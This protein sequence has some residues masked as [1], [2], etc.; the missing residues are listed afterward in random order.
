MSH[1]KF[2]SK[3]LQSSSKSDDSQPSRRKRS[4]A[5]LIST[6]TNLHSDMTVAEIHAIGEEKFH[7][8]SKSEWFRGF[9][10]SV[11][12]QSP[13]VDVIDSAWMWVPDCRC[14]S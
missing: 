10:C 4:I 13:P 7:L 8:D 12:D 6:D 2:H 1:S 3:R 9:W 11:R 5:F 14:I